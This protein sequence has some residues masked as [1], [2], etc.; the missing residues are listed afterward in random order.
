MGHH[1][2]CASAGRGHAVRLF[3]FRCSGLNDKYLSIFPGNGEFSVFVFRRIKS[4]DSP[5]DS[6]FAPCRGHENFQS[7]NRVQ[8]SNLR[9]SPPLSVRILQ[10]MVVNFRLS[11][12]ENTITSHWDIT[13]YDKTIQFGFSDKCTSIYQFCGVPALIPPFASFQDSPQTERAADCLDCRLRSELTCGGASPAYSRSHG[14]ERQGES[15]FQGGFSGRD[16]SNFARSF[17]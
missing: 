14:E 17:C 7:H 11:R 5:P 2:F 3:Y 13:S 8:R 1:F 10:R 15:Y 4:V 9:K 12:T 16:A 6:P